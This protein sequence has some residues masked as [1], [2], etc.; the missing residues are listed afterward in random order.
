VFANTDFHYLIGGYAGDSI[1]MRPP[2]I[3][4]NISIWPNNVAV[5][6]G[7][8]DPITNG[9]MP[10]DMTIPHTYTLSVSNGSVSLQLDDGVVRT[11][12]YS[13]DISQKVGLFCSP[14]Y[15]ADPS[16]IFQTSAYKF[17]ELK[18]Y[19]GSSISN[20]TLIHHYYP[21]YRMSDDV[22]GIY[23]VVTDT[24]LT[25]VGTG[26]LI[27]GS[28]TG[29]PVI[30]VQ[31][32][33][34][35]EVDVSNDLN[36]KLGD[37]LQFDADDAIEVKLGFGLQFDA[38]GAIEATGGGGTEYVA[39]QGIE[40]L[41]S[42]VNPDYYFDTQVQC[43]VGHINSALKR[44]F[45]KQTTEPAIGAL[46]TKYE[47]GFND[48]LTGPMFVSEVETA[49]S[50]GTSQDAVIHTANA[51]TLNYR[52]KTWYYSKSEYYMEND[53]IVADELGNME[54]INIV[55]PLNTSDEDMA[56]AIIDAA[57]VVDTDTIQAK[58]GVGLTFDSNDAIELDDSITIRFNC[59]NDPNEY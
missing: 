2:S 4:Y 42:D 22:P 16:A 48:P 24:F 1:G 37:G 55:F 17:Y 53:G 11:A 15:T 58:L 54:N 26:D 52:G 36:V 56:K 10:S 6:C 41:S 3:D 34:G 57:Y 47:S 44:T 5:P 25:N 45:T 23:D 43:R 12:S 51:T 39:G 19:E 30:N 29:T 20:L 31:Y 14:S 9:E 33:D 7:R 38:N 49:V 13:G 21:C 27:I 46:I 8:N 59:N 35:L 28:I 32:G 18:I 40:I 50:Y